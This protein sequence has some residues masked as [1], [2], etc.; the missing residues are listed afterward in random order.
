MFLYKE[1]KQYLQIA[2][3]NKE[4]YFVYIGSAVFNQIQ[5]MP[6]FSIYKASMILDET[7][8]QTLENDEKITNSEEF[9]LSIKKYLGNEKILEEV[10]EKTGFTHYEILLDDNENIGCAIYKVTK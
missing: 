10:L 3:E 6:E 5:S 8:I 2:E 7:Q 9:V 4:N 1:Y